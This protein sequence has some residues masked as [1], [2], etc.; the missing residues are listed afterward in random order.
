SPFHKVIL[1]IVAKQDGERNGNVSKENQPGNDGGKTVNERPISGTFPAQ[2]LKHGADSV[3][4]MQEQQKHGDD[5][6]GR[7]DGTAETNHHHRKHIV[8]ILGVL[9]FREI[10]SRQVDSGR[11]YCEMQEVINDE[12]QDDQSAHQHGARR[13]TGGHDL[14]LRIGL[15]PRRPV[16]RREFDG[17]PD[18]QQDQ[19]EEDDPRRPED[20]GVGLQQVAIAVDGFRPQ[21]DLQIPQ[22]VQQHEQ[23]KRQAGYGHDE[24]LSQ[25]RCK[26]VA[27]VHW[28][29]FK[30]F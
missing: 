19:N 21:K 29:H 20:F 3:A 23:E 26:Q 6:K 4:Q 7:N 5:I 11:L 10:P 24:L 22:Q 25:R 8:L 9:Q 27:S 18:V 17:R 2:G 28:G 15:R 13:I 30:Y 14:I 1:S 12:R 16:F